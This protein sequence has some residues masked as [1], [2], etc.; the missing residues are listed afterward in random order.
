MINGSKKI[1][2]GKQKSF[3]TNKNG[4][5]PY[6]NLNDAAMAVVRGNF[7]AINT[8]IKNQERKEERQSRKIQINNPILYLKTLEKEKKTGPKV[9]R[10]KEIIKI[11]TEVNEILNRKTIEKMK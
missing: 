1:L 10:W 2:K 3:L 6:Q 9:S 8:Y 5:T 11:R 4:S 7:I